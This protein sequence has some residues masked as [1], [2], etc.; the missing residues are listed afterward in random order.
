MEQLSHLLAGWD[1]GGLGEGDW[2]W[3]GHWGEVF[4]HQLDLSLSLEW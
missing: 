4:W 3:L 1:C 2:H